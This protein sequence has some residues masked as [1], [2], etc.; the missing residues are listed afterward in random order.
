M[1]RQHGWRGARAA[2]AA[3]LAVIVLAACTPA[4]RYVD[5]PVTSPVPDKVDTGEVVVGVNNIAGG[6]NPHDIADQSAITTALAEVL[7]P[8]VFRPEIGRAHV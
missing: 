5:T 8:S 2:V 3:A 1:A 6:Y 4:P 7:L